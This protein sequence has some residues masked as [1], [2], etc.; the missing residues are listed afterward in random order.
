MGNREMMANWAR[1][2]PW[3]RILI[4]LMLLLL[5]LLSSIRLVHH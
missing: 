5:F 2:R 1:T 3:R 4:E